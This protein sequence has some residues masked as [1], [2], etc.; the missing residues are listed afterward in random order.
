[1]CN[2]VS[3]EAERIEIN[4]KSEV[5]TSPPKSGI[6]RGKRLFLPLFIS[7]GRQAHDSPLLVDTTI[8]KQ[9]LAY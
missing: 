6:N 9:L 3:L 2:L 1:M 4:S 7:L 5:N 8:C